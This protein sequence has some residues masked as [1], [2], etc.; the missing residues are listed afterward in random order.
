M[1]MKEEVHGPSLETERDALIAQGI[2][3]SRSFSENDR[4]SMIAYDVP[5][6]ASYERVVEPWMKLKNG[7]LIWQEDIKQ[8]ARDYR[9]ALPIWC[10][11][12]IPPTALD[13][14]VK[15]LGA[16]GEYTAFVIDQIG[17]QLR[18]GLD[19]LKNVRGDVSSSELSSEVPETNSPIKFVIF[20]EAKGD[21]QKLKYLINNNF[22][23][24]T[25]VKRGKHWNNLY[26]IAKD[27]SVNLSSPDEA[28][29]LKDYFN[30][31]QRNRLWSDGKRERHP[32][33]AI[34]FKTRVMPVS[35]V[36]FRI[37]THR[38]WVQRE[39]KMKN[40]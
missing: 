20:K 26:Q 5:D 1:S 19:V 29:D 27:G 31:E 22:K 16:G 21:N 32:L 8:L 3:L 11:L 23:E 30:S 7:C 13:H 6:T 2:N 9:I 39:R 10:E 25:E 4:E 15:G 36:V 37:Y 33:L 18:K 12:L 40:Q 35:E 24:V 17:I 34:D 38:Q 14:L 28:K